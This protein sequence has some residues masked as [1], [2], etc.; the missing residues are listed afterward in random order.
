MGVGNG[1][2]KVDDAL[3][4]TKGIPAGQRKRSGCVNHKPTKVLLLSTSILTR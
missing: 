2:F 1:S 3:T 4:Q